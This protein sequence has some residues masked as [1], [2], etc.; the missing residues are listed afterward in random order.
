MS[1]KNYEFLEAFSIPQLKQ[2][3]KTA[4]MVKRVNLWLT[5]KYEKIATKAKCDT[6]MSVTVETRR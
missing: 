4:L 6:M 3:T 1:R 5:M 2:S